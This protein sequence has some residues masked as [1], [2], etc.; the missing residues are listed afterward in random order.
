M[1]VTR[2]YR[3]EYR[4]WTSAA[5]LGVCL[6][7]SAGVLL[8]TYVVSAVRV[9]SGSMED[10][11]LP[12]DH[13]L[14]NKLVAPRSFVVQ[15]PFAPPM[16]V[17]LHIPAVRSI[18]LGEVLV[19]RPPAGLPHGLPPRDVYLLK[20]CVGTPGDTLCFTGSTLSVN[21]RGVSFPPTARQERAPD[22]L[23]ETAGPVSVIV[24]PGSYYV[25][26]DNPGDSEDSRAWGPVPYASIVGSAAMIYWSVAP[27]SP[28]RLPAS[29]KASVR[30]DRIGVLVR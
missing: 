6:A 18:R 27:P 2:V 22:L 13:V 11:I 3:R 15:F 23:T 14:V 24:P 21:G 29:G 1:D 26:G 16:P 4:Q 25:M 10:T 5:L 17:I 28:G 12:G 19:I 7:V 30:W 9:P 20:R 8:R